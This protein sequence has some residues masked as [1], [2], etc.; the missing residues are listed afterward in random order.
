MNKT[1]IIKELTE[2]FVLVEPLKTSYTE[3]ENSSLS[4]LLSER[5]EKIFNLFG[6]TYSPRV[7]KILDEFIW[8]GEITPESLEKIISKYIVIATEVLSKPVI[9]F[10]KGEDDR[11]PI[12]FNDKQ[13]MPIDTGEMFEYVKKNLLLPLDPTEFHHIETGFRLLWNR[14]GG[15]LIGDWDFQRS[16]DQYLTSIEYQ[17]DRNRMIKI[18]DLILE[19][20]EEIGQWG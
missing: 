17:V 8:Q 12:R 11:S 20:L 5:A 19:Y 15:Q 18:V 9:S 2:L 10:S 13:I 4:P 7:G 1:Q 6:L 14:S 16:V 3:L